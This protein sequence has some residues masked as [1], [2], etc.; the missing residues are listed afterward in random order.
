MELTVD[1]KIHVQEDEHDE[2]KPRK[3]NNPTLGN[4]NYFVTALFN[5]QLGSR[6]SHDGRP[7]RL[8]AAECEGEG[9][10]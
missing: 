4:G 8:Q 1:N 7:H 5:F 6:W 2:S 9:S 10:S 3:T